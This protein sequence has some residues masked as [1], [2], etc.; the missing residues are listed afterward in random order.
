M[1]ESYTGSCRE[2]A[3]ITKH[4]YFLYQCFLQFGI[5]GQEVCSAALFSPPPFSSPLPCSLLTFL[6]LSLSGQGL[7][8][9]PRLA[10]N[11]Q[12]CS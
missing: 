11:S 2:R 10:S 4:L 5:L 3:G 1:K 8:V 9:W 7:T 12:S 6:S